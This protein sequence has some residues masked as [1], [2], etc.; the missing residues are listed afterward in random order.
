MPDS[1]F[2]HQFICKMLNHCANHAIIEG[3]E[4]T[5]EIILYSSDLLR[6]IFDN[7][8][9]TV[10]LEDEIDNIETFITIQSLNGVNCIFRRGNIKD[11]SRCIFLPHLS[12]LRV[13]IEDIQHFYDHNDRNAEIVY[14]AEYSN[15]FPSIKRVVNG[16]ENSIFKVPNIL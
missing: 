8:R 7:R 1:L 2:N 11:S 4:N 15:D 12:V 9:T 3:A 10:T 5:K 14:E 13:F 6:Y 16:I